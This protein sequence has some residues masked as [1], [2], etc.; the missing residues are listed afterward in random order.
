VKWG[1]FAVALLLAGVVGWRVTGSPSEAAPPTTAV[2]RIFV[3]KSDHRMIVFSGGR[4]VRQFQV[5]LGRGGLAPKTR[6][7]DGR[8]PEGNYRITGLNPNSAFYRSLRIGY[9]TRAQTADA[10]RR[11]IDPGNDIMIHGLPNGRGA[12][13]KR[14]RLVDWTQG[15]IAV[16]NEEMD[17]LWAAVAVGTPIEIVQ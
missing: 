5:A 9:P 15:C 11:G 4:A 16:T 14:H 1:A 13:G 12:L 10:R 7:G 6:Q 17:W 8:V 2:D 3:D